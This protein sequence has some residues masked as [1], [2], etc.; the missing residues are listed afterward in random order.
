MK[1]MFSNSKK[2]FG[3]KAFGA[4]KVDDMVKYKSP[5]PDIESDSEDEMNHVIKEFKASKDAEIKHYDTVTSA[6]YYFAVYFADEAQ[7][8]EFIDKVKAREYFDKTETFIAGKDLADLLG[9]EI[10]DTRIKRQGYFKKGKRFDLGQ[11]I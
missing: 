3:K 11:Y 7:K 1:D 2:A 8:N 10:S 6:N 4:K 9:I 5:T